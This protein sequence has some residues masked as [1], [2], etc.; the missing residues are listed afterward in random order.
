MTTF[1]PCAHPCKLGSWDFD[2]KKKEPRCECK[3]YDPNRRDRMQ[4]FDWEEFRKCVAD[5][6]PTEAAVIVRAFE[7][8]VKGND[9][10]KER[11]SAEMDD[12]FE[13][14]KSAW[15]LSEMFTAKLQRKM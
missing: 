5:M 14:F 13:T 15:I 9:A 4:I 11:S 6:R 8:Y 12:S 1:G 2:P 3:A 10:F 7:Q